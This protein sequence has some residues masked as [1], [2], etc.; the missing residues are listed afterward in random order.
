MKKSPKRPR[1]NEAVGTRTGPRARAAQERRFTDPYSH[2]E[3]PGRPRFERGDAGGRP[4]GARGAVVTLD[5]DV[6][7][8]FRDSAAVNEVLRLVIRL[9]RFGGGRPPFDRGRPGPA[10]AERRPVPAG[11]RSSDRRPPR[12]QRPRFDE[13]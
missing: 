1:P 13:E 4:P 2:A 11:E 7:R 12:P 9:A 8:V 5:P 6:A 10:F 3:R